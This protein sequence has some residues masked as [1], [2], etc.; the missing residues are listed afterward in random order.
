[1][2]GIIDLF[3]AHTGRV[4]IQKKRAWLPVALMGSVVIQLPI[5]AG[6]PRV[7]GLGEIGSYETAWVDGLLPVQDLTNQVSFFDFQYEGNRFLSSGPYSG[8][9]SPGIGL[10]HAFQDD[11][12]VGAYIF[13]DYM[14][15]NVHQNY[16]LLGPGFDYY[17]G[18]WYAS[19]NGYIPVNNGKRLMS[20]V[21]ASETG[22][23]QYEYFSNH[24]QYDR[25]LNVYDS[26]RWGLDVTGGVL[27]RPDNTWGLK[28]GMYVYGGNNL[29]TITGGHG[30]VDYF[31]RDNL[32]LR[33]EE[34]Y[35]SY[36]GNQTVIGVSVSFG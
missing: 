20:S 23:T 3:Y 13:S 19:M 16:W 15:T 32:V 9:L 35:D 27:F 5:Y 22:N 30:E 2:V 24:D 10:R 33:I 26:M 4:M 11:Q 25:L 12:V 7:T 21:P 6:N 28:G 18:R 8:I 36:F 34:R 31:V 14:S 29:E 17:H 1:M